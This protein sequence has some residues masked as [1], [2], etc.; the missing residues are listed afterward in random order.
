[1]DLYGPNRNAKPARQL[2]VAMAF[3]KQGQYLTLSRREL[4]QCGWQLL[5]A[6]LAAQ[7]FGRQVDASRKNQADGAQHHLWR[8]GFR[9]E[10]ESPRFDR[11]PDVARLVFR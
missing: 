4:R 6:R 8:R 5:R 1:M 9:D 11:L 2:L 7:Q 3:G 10:T